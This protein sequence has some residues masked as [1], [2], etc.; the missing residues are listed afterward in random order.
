MKVVFFGTSSFAVPT[1]EAIASSVIQVVSQPCRPSGRGL[2]NKDS[3][4]TDAA[5][6]LGLPVETPER[7]REAGFVE[8]IR[9]LEPDVLVVAAY[10]QILPESLLTAARRGAVNV[11]ASLLPEYRGAAPI[12]HAL[13][14]DRRETGVTLMQMERGLDTGD[15]IA[16]V[17]TPIDPT[18][19]YGSLH[20][21][22]ARLGAE[23]TSKWLERIVSGRYV[24]YPQ[25]RMRAS[26]APKIDRSEFSIRVD[27]AASEA[28]N[29]Y[30]ALTPPG[31]TFETVFGPLKIRALALRSETQTPGRLVGFDPEPVIAFR[32]GSLMLV[33]VMPPGRKAM[34]GRD[35]A[36]GL[37][38]R[39]GDAVAVASTVR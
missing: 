4:V 28:F 25:D 12:Q 33:E 20:D 21:R 13:L 15:I 9:A 6:R 8:R 16:A 18:E 36:N 35:W 1:L 17:S 30:R 14:D 24:R 22:L 38:L 26:Y 31:V 2:V 10:G 7:C 34:S 23:L 11:H 27:Q 39:P 19:T 29:R 32:Y 37:R 3:P 5:R